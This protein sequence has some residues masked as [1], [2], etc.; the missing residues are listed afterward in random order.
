MKNTQFKQTEIGRIPVDWEVV[1]LGVIGSFSKGK[2][3]K[4]DEVKSDGFPCVRYGELY[5]KYNNYI[6]FFHSFISNEVAKESKRIKYGDILFAGSGETK[7]DIGKCAAMMSNEIVYAGGDVIIFTPKNANSLFLGYLLNDDKIKLQK[8][9]KGQGDAVVHIYPYGLSKIKIPV[10]P[11]PEQKAIAT[12]LSNIDDLIHQLDQL[13]Q[14][15]KA[16]K[17]G[18][19]QELLTGRK[20]LEGF[21]SNGYKNTEVGVIP[22]DWKI[23]KIDDFAK[24]STGDKDTQDKIDDGIYPFFVR[25]QIIERIN[26]YSF[27]GEAVITSGDGV[28]VGKVFHYFNGKFDY[29][30][31]VYNIHNFDNHVNGKYFFFQFFSNFYD[32]VMAMTAKSSVDSVRREM[33]AEMK[34]PFPS[35]PEQTAIAHVLS[36]MDS[37]IAALEV[38]KHKTALLK[39]GMMQE[40]LTG[41]TRLV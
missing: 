26:S 27:N 10:P 4:K 40:L 16:I 2:G 33:I 30:Q 39:Q 34:I 20:R 19:M 31:R 41:K 5:T 11:L 8:S 35:L 9:Q 3:I 23:E 38:R 18:A 36:D 29:H 6:K 13:I 32:R 15:K 25:S 1:E 7:E 12:A 14:K 37:E 21:N 17:Q 28:G 24:I 22:N